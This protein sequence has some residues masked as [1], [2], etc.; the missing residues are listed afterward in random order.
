MKKS[1]LYMLMFCSVSLG[2]VGWRIQ[3]VRSGTTPHFE[4]V[5]DPSLS[6]REGCGSLLGLAERAF[7]T[8]SITRRSTLTVL[9]LGDA[10]TADEPWEF[11]KY[12][13]PTSNRAMESPAA[14]LR[15]RQSVLQDIRSRCQ[16]IHR[17]AV[18]PI[19][20]GVKQAIADLRV[21]GCRENS[22]CEIFVD[23]DLE[24]NREAYVKKMLEGDG[25]PAAP[26][27]NNAG[28]TVTFCGVAV[29]TGSITD[30]PDRRIRRGRPLDLNREARLQGVWD[31]VF[32][33]P[34]TVTFEPYCPDARE[35]G[36]YPT[37]SSRWQEGHVEKR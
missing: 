18:S 28:I 16:A 4:I 22:G 31:S 12:L 6:H 34:Q 9:V 15:R 20:L 11:G 36:P 23:S 8:E 14:N 21:Q 29:T 13:I 33:E 19:F 1:L 32:T 17:T 30:T 10:T 2:F 3:A 24:E 7:G 35:S 37:S 5:E 27:I 26:S 25:R